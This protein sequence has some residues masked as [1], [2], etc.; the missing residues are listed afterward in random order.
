MNKLFERKIVNI[1]LSISLTY[2]FWALIEMVLLS[3]HDI[4]FGGKIRKLIY[5]AFLSGPLTSLLKIIALGPK[6]E[7]YLGSH[8]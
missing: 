1:L 8:V 5:V 3:T 6:N 2:M 7:P 4:C